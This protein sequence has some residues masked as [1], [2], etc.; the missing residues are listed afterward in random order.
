MARISTSWSVQK[1]ASRVPKWSPDGSRI[2]YS[3]FDVAT[4]RV[5]THVIGADGRGHDVLENPPGVIYQ[6]FPVWSPDGRSVLVARGYWDDAVVVP[7][8]TAADYSRF[9]IITVD[10]TAPDVELCD[11]F[12]SY[13]RRVGLVTGRHQAR[14]RS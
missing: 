12:S 5:F 2:A 1:R 7:D 3:Q 11:C 4:N 14:Q 9:A 13:E 10:G 6:L 8:G